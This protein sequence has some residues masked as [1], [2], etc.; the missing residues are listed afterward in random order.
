MTILAAIGIAVSA[1]LVPRVA[2]AFSRES[3]A[4]DWDE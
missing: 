2:P 3:P 1:V 4:Y